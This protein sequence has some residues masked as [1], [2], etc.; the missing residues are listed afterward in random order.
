M[1]RS[2]KKL[3]QKERQM[4]RKVRA[5]VEKGDMQAARMYAN[6]VV[7]SRKWA[8]GYQ[9]LNSKIEGLMFKLERTDAVQSLAG[10]M[11][12]VATSLK[13]ASEALS[14]AGMDDIIQ[15]LEESLEDVEIS[16]EMMEE[17]VD[18][19]FA[20]DIEEDEVDNLLAEYGAEVGISASTGLPSPVTTTPTGEK[21]NIT[22]LEKEIE[23]LRKQ[24]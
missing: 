17:S 10:E 24:D 8:R 6:D 21:T 2:Q 3:E 20:G 1:Q 19:L 9:S 5:A 14:M 13:A 18:G 22:D 16:S 7:R 12:G 23:D 15:D 11:K 4:E